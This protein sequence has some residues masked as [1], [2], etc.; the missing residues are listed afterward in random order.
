MK[1]W[2]LSFFAL[3]TLPLVSGFDIFG[4]QFP[5]DCLQPGWN[6]YN[7]S[8]EPITTIGGY[9]YGYRVYMNATQSTQ[10]HTNTTTPNSTTA[11]TNSTTANSTSNSTASNSTNGTSSNKSN[12][13][14]STNS[15][16]NKTNSTSKRLRLPS[17]VEERFQLYSR[18][19]QGFVRLAASNTTNST[20]SSNS[21]N[22][23]SNSST[24]V[25]TPVS[26]GPPSTYGCYH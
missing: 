3:F 24:I 13:S 4:T 25:Y 22:S 2:I 6:F 5:Q 12:S 20:N 23:T 18:R 10:S 21:T 11:G 26:Q 19:S 8:V 15:T 9:V 14:N 17:P 1:N 16:S 7:G